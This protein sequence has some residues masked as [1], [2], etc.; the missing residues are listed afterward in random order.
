MK[1]KERVKVIITVQLA[2]NYRAIIRP[3]ENCS[4]DRIMDYNA[5]IT[6]IE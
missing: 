2:K 4:S 6:P 1:E 5:T 3:Q